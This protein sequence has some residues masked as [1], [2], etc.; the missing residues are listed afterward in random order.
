[1]WKGVDDGEEKIDLKEGVVRNC[2]EKGFRFFED[3]EYRGKKQEHMQLV[4]NFLRA[5]VEV[6]P[7]GQV[8][9]PVDEWRKEMLRH[10]NVVCVD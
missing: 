5:I 4:M 3:V 7:R 8:N 6:M 2:R 9:K 1:L 10:M